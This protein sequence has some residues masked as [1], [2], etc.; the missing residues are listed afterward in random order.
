MLI[1]PNVVP[2]FFFF[3]AAQQQ[4]C[5]RSFPGREE[6]GRDLDAA[7]HGNRRPDNGKWCKCEQARPP[8]PT[9]QGR[10]AALA[11]H[12]VNVPQEFQLALT[13]NGCS[14]RC[15]VTVFMPIPNRLCTCS[16]DFLVVM[17]DGHCYGQFRSW[18]R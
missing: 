6:H 18:P 13:I 15:S 16:I 9:S 5:R 8:T 11:V 14:W 17:T 10:S 4:R 1:K 7:P 2:F 3:F 12:S